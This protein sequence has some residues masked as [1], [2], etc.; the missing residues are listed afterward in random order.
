MFNRA[1]TLGMSKGTRVRG[2]ATKAVVGEI[3]AERAR[4][5]AAVARKWT[6]PSLSEATG[7]PKDTIKSIDSGRAPLDMD[8][9]F[10]I[11]AALGVRASELV[12]RAEGQVRLD[13]GE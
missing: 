13:A 9:L 4:Q 8:Q 1:H 7:I 6:Q 11:A 12:A 3:K 5:N 2:R 10:V